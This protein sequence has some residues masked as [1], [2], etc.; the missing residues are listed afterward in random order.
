MSGWKRWLGVAVAAAGVLSA[1][2][3]SAQF[4]TQLY[5]PPGLPGPAIS[6]YLSLSRNLGSGGFGFGGF[7]S[8]GLNYYG[9]VRPQ[10]ALR[11]QLY[12]LQSQVG[13]NTLALQA[14]AADPFGFYATGHFARYNNLSHYYYFPLT[15]VGGAYGT[16]YGRPGL[17]GSMTGFGQRGFGAG[18]L[19]AGGFGA[20]GLGGAGLGA[21]GLRPGAVRPATGGVG[22]AGGGRGR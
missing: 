6:P 20:G 15:G 9:F 10:F 13:A 14:G 4:P 7:G 5:G 11:N 18:G 3:A 12:G 1:S 17:A 19:G 2:P 21:G 16:G 22:G 8:P